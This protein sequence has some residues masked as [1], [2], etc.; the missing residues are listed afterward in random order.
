[1]KIPQRLRNKLPPLFW[2]HLAVSLLVGSSSGFLFYVFFL[3][4]TVF[5]RRY[6]LLDLGIVITGSLISYS[7]LKQ[8]PF[9]FKNDYFINRRSFS[10]VCLLFFLALP[11]YWFLPPYPELPFF[12]R[13][14]NLIITVR[15][16]AEPVTWSQFRKIYL[17]SGAEKWGPKGFHLSD[18]WISRR[19]DFILPR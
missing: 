8:H 16:G 14:S 12:Q 11:F 19:D 15:T 1:M 3:Q 5:S 7:L 17:N 13:K 6:L 18:T 10:L 2:K 4:T 9:A